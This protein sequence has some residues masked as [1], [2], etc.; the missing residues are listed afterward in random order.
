MV[1]ARTNGWG[2][3]MGETLDRQAAHPGNGPL[4]S[5]IM[6]CLNGES[7]LREA[8]DSVFAQTYGNWEIIFFDNSSTDSS[9]VIAKSY[10]EKLRYFH[11]EQTIPLGAARNAAISSARG[12]LIAF[13]DTD[14]RWLPEKLDWQVALFLKQPDVD[15]AYGNF[16][17]TRPGSDRKHLGFRKKQPQGHVF[18]KFLVYFPINLQTVMLRK[19]ILDR[20]PELF[21]TKL[22]LAEDYDL[23]MRLLYKT[24]AGYI[25]KPLA[26]YRLHLGMSSIRFAEKY[27]DE[28]VYC[29]DKLKA[30]HSELGQE[31]PKE[32]AYLDAKIAYWRAKADI[33]HGR[34]KV[35]RALLKPHIGKGMLFGGLYYATYLP[36]GLWMKLQ[37]LR[38]ILR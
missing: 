21:D 24:K 29:I 15:F 33:L 16:Y 36:F 34:T 35:A 37:G 30:L 6:N 27:P 14:D 28:M 26:V 22:N 31:F 1:I 11:S 10:G 17:F 2:Q 19:S 4:V 23:F 3:S 25:D 7:Y 8:I 5:V 9:E 12:N 20:L 18:G 32:L 38:L 13:L